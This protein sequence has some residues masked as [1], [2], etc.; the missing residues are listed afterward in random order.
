MANL[1]GEVLDEFLIPNLAGG[2]GLLFFDRLPID[3][4]KPIEQFSVRVTDHNLS[5][6]SQV[7]AGYAPRNPAILFA[8]MARQWTGWPGEL[9]WESIEGELILRCSHDG[10]GHISVGIELRRGPEPD[11][12]QIEATILTEAGQLQQ[13]AQRAASFFGLVEWLM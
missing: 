3:R 6:V 7:H 8:E 1:W 12:W 10:R 13:I 4:T 2:G 9:V 11:D 5:A